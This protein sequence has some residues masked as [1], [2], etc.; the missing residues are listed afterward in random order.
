MGLAAPDAAAG[1]NDLAERLVREADKIRLPQ[2]D[3]QVEITITNTGGNNEQETRKYRVLSKGHDDTVVQTTYPPAERGQILLM[4]GRDLWAFMPA[5]SQPIRL[6][7]AQRLTGQVANGDLARANFAGD[8]TPALLRTE[9]ADKTEYYVLELRAADR[10]IT[11]H[12][13]LYWVA[14][15][16]GRPY[17]AEFFS[18]SGKLL[19]TCLYTEFRQAAGT[20][21]PTRMII[22]DALRQGNRSI[23][24]YEKFTLRALPDKLFTKDYLKKLQ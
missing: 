18:A 22:E 24:E 21:R 12:R 4:K 10:S 8:Y 20:M 17:K 1:S 14:K 15:A 19:K 7:L 3:F 5:V 16:N 23:L 6:S 11:Y 9:T 13:V 2:Q